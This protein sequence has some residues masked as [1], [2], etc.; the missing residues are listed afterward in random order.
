MSEKNQQSLS[1]FMK[2]QFSESKKIQDKKGSFGPAKVSAKAKDDAKKDDKD[3]KNPEKEMTEEE[4]VEEAKKASMG[5]A[6]RYDTSGM[7]KKLLIESIIKYTIIIAVLVIFAL[8]TIKAGPAAIDFFNSLIFK[9]L[10]SDFQK[11]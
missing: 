9:T 11:H 1:S 2:K 7:Y 4:K 3:G 8:G 5:K 10:T 6:A